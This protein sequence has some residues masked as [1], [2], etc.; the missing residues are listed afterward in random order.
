MAAKGGRSDTPLAQALFDRAYSF[1]FFQAVRLLERILPERQ[2]VGRSVDPAREIVRFRSQA[3]LAFPPSQIHQIRQ[4]SAQNGE[5]EDYRSPEMVIAFMGMT[6]PLG[7]LP[8]QYTELLMERSRYKDTALW[9]FLDLFTHRMVSLFYR[10]WE[11]HRFPIAYERGHFDQFTEYLFDIIGLGTPGLRGRLHQPDQGLL[12]YGGLI[13]QRPHSASALTSILSD[14]FDALARVEQFS[15]QWLELD[16]E[17]ISRLGVKNS[18]LGIS[19]VAG[20]RVWDDQSKFLLKLGPLTLSKFKTF[21]PVGSAFRPMEALAKFLVGMEFDFDIQ[22]ILKKEEVPGCSLNTKDQEQQPRLG[23]SSWLKTR[24][25]TADDS[26]VV[27]RT[28]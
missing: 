20:T 28:Q 7:V 8:Q 27:L 3:S 4:S 12:L 23:W 22:L 19:T 17:S 2:P 13:A 10:A 6:G 25:F 21:L 5:G 18:Q 14:H 24:A 16:D 26:Q 11:K 1:N 9:E 15:G